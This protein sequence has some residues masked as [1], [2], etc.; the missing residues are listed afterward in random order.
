MKQKQFKRRNN[1]MV[2][3]QRSIE[4]RKKRTHLL[5]QIGGTVEKV[6]D[7]PL[8]E[9]DVMRLLNFLNQQERNGKYFTRAME[10]CPDTGSE[11]EGTEND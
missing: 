5:C 8:V 7:R 11:M 3:T 1:L 10:K 4:E 2:R 9:E 6:L